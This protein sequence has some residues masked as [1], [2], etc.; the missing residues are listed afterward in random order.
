VTYCWIEHRAEGDVERR[1]TEIV[2]SPEHEYVIN[3]AGFRDPTM[4][5]VRMSLARDASPGYSDGKDVGAGAE[6]V[7]A[8]Y[9]WGTNLAKGKPYTLEGKQSDKNPDAGSDLTDGIIAPPEEYVS[10]KWMPTNVI[11]QQDAAPVA[12]IDLG[13][14]QTVAAVRVHAGQEAGFHLAFPESITVETSTDG[15]NYVKAGTAVH[16]QVF[17][18]P[19]DHADWE[20][21]DAPKYDA[22]PAG[23]RLAYG[24]RI[25][26]GTPVSARYVRVTCAPRKGWGL[27]LSEIQ[28]F[29]KATMETNLPPSVALRPLKSR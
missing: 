27:M 7:R 24:Y 8:R 29:D 26:F 25:L 19:A 18:P 9:G 12:T 2:K 22:L 23:G 21:K 14:P 15:K 13:G 10:V 28:V 3:V 17:D 16:D 20:L 11:F 6:P 4:K 5:W 1:H